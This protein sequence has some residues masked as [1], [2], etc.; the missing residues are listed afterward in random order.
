M[1]INPKVNTM[2]HQEFE[3][4]YYSLIIGMYTPRTT[5]FNILEFELYI[6]NLVQTIM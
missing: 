1:G 5:L 2:E 6:D 4:A 3:L